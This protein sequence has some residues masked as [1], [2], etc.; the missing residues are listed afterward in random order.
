MPLAQRQSEA[1]DAREWIA[2]DAAAPLM[3]VAVRTLCWR[4]ASDWSRHGL[5]VRRS[6]GRGRPRWFVKRVVDPRLAHSPNKLT[7]D[8]RARPKLL[9]SHPRDR[10]ERAYRKARW[11]GEWRSR[12]AMRPAGLT[13]RA[14]AERVVAD[15]KEVE[16]ADFR[17]AERTL[18][19]WWRDY[20]TLG[21]DGQ[22]RG[23]AALV[24]NY[25]GAPMLGDGDGS[26]DSR[27]PE[28]VAFF[29]S[30]WHTENKLGV[31]QCHELTRRKAEAEGWSW[32]D[33]AASTARWLERYDDKGASL[34]ARRGHGAFASSGLMPFAEQDWSRIAPGEMYVSDHKRCDFWVSE[35]TKLYRPWLTAVQD[36]RTRCIVGWHLGPAPHQD[37]IV[38]A[39]RMAL[40]D[41]SIPQRIRID[42][43]KDF[44]SERLTG[45]T[46]AKIRE[47]RAAHGKEWK[48][49][50]RAERSRDP[51]RVD[52]RSQE[53]V[54]R[55]VFAELGV[56][57]M[58]AQPYSPWVKGTVERW[59]RT[60]DERCGKLFSTWCGDKPDSKPECLKEALRGKT[61]V[62]AGA[63]SLVDH[64]V[65]PTLGEAKKRVAEYLHDYHATPHRGRGLDGGSPQ[66]A[67]NSVSSVRKADADALLLLLG[68]RGLYK[69]GGNG[70]S[71]SIDGGQVSFGRG[72]ARLRKYRGREVMVSVDIDHPSVA[73]AF[74][75]ATRRLID[76][77]EPN[78]W[79]HPATTHDELREQH[80]AIARDR[81]QAKKVARSSLRRTRNAIE[82]ANAVAARKTRALAATGTDH[83]SP[84]VVPVQVGFEPSL[85]AVRAPFELPVREAGIPLSRLA[86][87]PAPP[88]RRAGGFLMDLIRDAERP[89]EGGADVDVWD[90]LRRAGEASP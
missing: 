75:P 19:K 10:V 33:G 50:V 78:Q 2:L 42:N 36:C 39:L 11:L 13:D 80:A 82:R 1:L 38:S 60:F 62:E 3:G 6:V 16:G 20:N 18:Q 66:A 90:A 76:R 69:V 64:A 67:W 8:E 21:D 17:I 23:V 26:G 24:D 61:G 85:N 53:P 29:Y 84:S 55:G 4:A 5:A 74:D 27:S 25:G 30:C 87:L 56:E 79:M 32:P 51:G 41:W 58:F 37:A 15:A 70:V 63:L 34:L 71:V 31:A 57:V 46:K 54:W 9:E 12:L 48:S 28:A 68:V 77:L 83:A 72:S 81:A 49:V 22:V 43:G 65:I 52:L 89:Q 7:R 35:G 73:H 40:T 45:L 59:F 86:D 88:R 47:L 44:K 14:I